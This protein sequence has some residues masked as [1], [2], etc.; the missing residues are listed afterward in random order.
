MYPGLLL[1]Q[2]VCVRC[3]NWAGRRLTNF[4]LPQSPTF[5]KS[6]ILGQE[7]LGAV[8][9]G[10][11]TWACGCSSALSTF[12]E[13]VSQESPLIPTTEAEAWIICLLC[14]KASCSPDKWDNF[15]N[16]TLLSGRVWIWTQIFR[17][18]QFTWNYQPQ[19]RAFP[20]LYSSMLVVLPF[21]SN[22][23]LPRPCFST[24]PSIWVS[25]KK[26]QIPRTVPTGLQRISCGCRKG[27]C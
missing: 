22:L 12:K 9:F 6:W 18:L 19:P 8:G 27:S 21:C 26:A 15:P 11:C 14:R 4:F 13:E 10:E 16:L 25:Q 24:V 1:L 5:K 7:R 2:Q 17:I 20:H 23:K 3:G